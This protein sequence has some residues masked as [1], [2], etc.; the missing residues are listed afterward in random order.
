MCQV[1]GVEENDGTDSELGKNLRCLE[2]RES[3]CGRGEAEGAPK[4]VDAGEARKHIF[5]VVRRGF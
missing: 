2:N 4:G 5:V 1:L 3:V